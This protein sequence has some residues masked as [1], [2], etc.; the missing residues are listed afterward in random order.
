MI[1]LSACSTMK[2][3]PEEVAVVAPTEEARS[4]AS[5][6]YECSFIDMGDGEKSEFVFTPDSLKLKVTNAK[7]GTETLYLEEDNFVTGGFTYVQDAS[8]NR[9]QWPVKKIT[10]ISFSTKPKVTVHFNRTPAS[11]KPR[12]I[13]KICN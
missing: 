11:D 12:S 2:P 5:K 6:E 13:T 1:L 10:F 8:K 4:V 7:Y 3:M 9:S